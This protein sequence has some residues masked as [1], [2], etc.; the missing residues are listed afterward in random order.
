MND[1][2]ESVKL[3]IPILSNNYALYSQ[4]FTESPCQRKVFS[5][6]Y[7]HLTIVE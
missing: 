1:K 5:I 4:H 2:P 3:K 7:I 6:L